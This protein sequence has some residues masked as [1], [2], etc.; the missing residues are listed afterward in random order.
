MATT[1]TKPPL[2]WRLLRL[3]TIHP[4][5]WQRAILVEGV[6]AVAVILVLADVASAWT[7]LALPLVSAAIVKGHDVL[8]G[9]LSARSVKPRDEPRSGLERLR[10]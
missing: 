7:L 6:A 4:N 3:R 1:E 5:G 9:L 8:A 10:L 2:Y